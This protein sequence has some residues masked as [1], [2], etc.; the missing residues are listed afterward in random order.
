MSEPLDAAALQ[1]ASVVLRWLATDEEHGNLWAR[2]DA[3]AIV[4]ASWRGAAEAL[5]LAAEWRG[6]QQP[7]C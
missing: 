1:A 6:G 3:T 5:R 7:G 2:E 4:L